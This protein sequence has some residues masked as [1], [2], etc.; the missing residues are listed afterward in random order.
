MCSRLPANA[1][2]LPMRPPFCRNS[3]VS[4]VKI[5]PTSRLNRSTS[6]SISS[7]LVPRSSR[8]WIASP[9]IAIAADAV[10]VSTTRTLSPSSAAA[11]RA[12]SNVPES[13]A[14]IWSE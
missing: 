12:L 2:A 11:V 6:S 10:P 4:T 14:A 13:V 1:A 7:S 9:S 8:R 5:S 3:S